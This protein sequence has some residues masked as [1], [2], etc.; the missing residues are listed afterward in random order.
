M[1]SGLFSECVPGL[2]LAN[3]EPLTPPRLALTVEPEPSL[4]PLLTG[5]EAPASAITPEPRCSHRKSVSLPQP[6]ECLEK[7]LHEKG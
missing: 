2:L 6:W 4:A 3:R 7:L 1:T 5:L